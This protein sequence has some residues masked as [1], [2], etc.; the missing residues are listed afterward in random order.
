MRKVY[1]A[2]SL[3]EAHMLAHELD[4]HEIPAAVQGEADP[5]E[6]PTVWI[7]RDDDL[8]RARAIV[9]AL[10]APEPASAASPPRQ[11]LRA[12]HAL[13][14]ALA[15]TVVAFAAG[16]A[17]GV[18]RVP[19]AEEVSERAADANGD[20]RYDVWEEYERGRITA[21]TY[22]TNF[23]GRPDEWQRFGPDGVM[24]QREYDI[25]HDGRVDSW[26]RCADGQLAEGRY[27]VDGDGTVDEWRTFRFGS[28]VERARSFGNDGIV[29]KKELHEKGR[30]VR[31][32]LDR[33]R[34]GEFDETIEY[35][36][37]ER[38]VRRAR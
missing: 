12:S 22:D 26:E 10:G 8:E 25:D 31:E 4:A 2:T 34:D 3:A 30:K 9:E 14:A 17:I 38:P 32:F 33:D 13:G 19:P 23:D 7:E 37:F 21:A 5:L 29:D 24:R 28:V 27:D 11:P 18:R 35:D 1:R 15:A 16:Y 20:G 36:A 6:P